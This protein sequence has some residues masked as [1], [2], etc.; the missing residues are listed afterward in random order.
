[1]PKPG[2]IDVEKEKYWR[3]IF[4]KCEQSGLGV[5]AFCR[6]ES[7]KLSSFCDW[8]RKLQKRDQACPLLSLS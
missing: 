3:G 1:M 7:I 6:Q 5:T 4:L 2:G 8:R